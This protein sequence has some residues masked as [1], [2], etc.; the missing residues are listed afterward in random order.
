MS[1]PVRHRHSERGSTLVESAV[2]GV[3]FLLLLVGIMEFGRIGFAYNSVS[4]AA[5]RAARYAALRGSGSGHPA[6]AA[7][8]QANA[9]AY[10]VAFDTSNLTVTTAWTPDNHPGSTVQVNVSYGFKTV[11]VPIS[12][13]LF[14][15]RTTCRQIIIQ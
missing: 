4:F 14:T 11:L 9:Q 12:A 6:S 8:V 10:L 2:V 3:V 1:I 7:D 13:D 15:L 5:H